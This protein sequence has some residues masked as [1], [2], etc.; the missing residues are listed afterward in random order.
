M[1]GSG[2]YVSL[3]LLG[4]ALAQSKRGTQLARRLMDMLW[5]HETLAYSTISPRATS[6]YHQLDP[7][8]IRAIEG[9]LLF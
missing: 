5:D 6:S 7:N 9:P 3:S 2:V 4:R 1:A 8:T